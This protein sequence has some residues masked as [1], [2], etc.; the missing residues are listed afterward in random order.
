M[1][2]RKS[3]IKLIVLLTII[4][5]TA[6]KAQSQTNSEI[7]LHT[8]FD[9]IV[10]K[11]NLGLNNGPLALNPYRTIGDNNMFFKNNKYTVGNLVYDGQPYFN[12]KLKYDIFKDQLILNPPEQPEHIG[13][14]L[15]QD[16]TDSFFIYGKNFIKITKSQTTLPDFTSGFYEIIKIGKNFNLFIKHHKDI[17]KGINE[18]GVYYSFN[19]NYQYY[20]EYK[21]KFY[22]TNNKTSIVKIFP[23]SKKNINAFYQ[24]N[25]S[26]SKTDYNQFI[27]SLMISIYDSSINNSK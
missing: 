15:I 6:F 11:E 10:G 9:S 24:R 14:N 27:N 1:Q 25:R 7:L 2:F 5:T 16:K 4:T 17:L 21:G 26:L 19:D 23:E 18:E 8:K 20:I 13:I 3:R 22:E 12:V